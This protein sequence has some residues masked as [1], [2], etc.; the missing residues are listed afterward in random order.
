MA[1]SV[2]ITTRL[3][4]QHESIQELIAGLSEQEL[5]QRV[6]PDKWS[7]FEQIAHLTAYQPLFLKRLYK[8]VQEDSPG[9]DRYVAEQDEDFP[10]M[11]QKPLMTL[12]EELAALRLI[13]CKY[14]TDM[15]DEVLQ[16]RGRHPKY[17]LLTIPEWSNFFLLHEAH[18]LYHVFMLTR[19]LRL[20]QP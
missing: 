15:P 12:L 14:L 11:L 9:F 4:Y 17:G 8:I 1:L 16:R 13:I 10:A 2:A 20:Q 3:Q 7:A 18:H 19:E 6:Q 5:K